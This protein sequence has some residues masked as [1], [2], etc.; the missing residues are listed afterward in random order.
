MSFLSHSHNSQSSPRKERTTAKRGRT[1][2]FLFFFFKSKV[3]DW[4]Y[5]CRVQWEFA[6]AFNPSSDEQ[7]A[8]AVQRLRS[9]SRSLLA[10]NERLELISFNYCAVNA[11]MH[12]AI[13]G[14]LPLLCSLNTQVFS[15]YINTYFLVY[16]KQLSFGNFSKMTWNRMSLPA[17][18]T[19]YSIKSVVNRNLKIKSRNFFPPV[20]YLA[21][22]ECH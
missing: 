6:S 9:R 5:T 10:L 1:T 2:I 16:N 12:S 15:F 22:S 7:W 13:Q 19:F 20:L 8:S 17:S 11:D 4:S 21:H 3:L 18:C 14:P